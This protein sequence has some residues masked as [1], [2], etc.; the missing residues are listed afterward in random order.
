MG[1]NIKFALSYP[2][3]AVPGQPFKIFII[4]TNSGDAVGSFMVSMESYI[5][6]NQAFTAQ[7]PSQHG[8]PVYANVPADNQPYIF[9]LKE[10]SSAW[11]ADPIM[12]DSWNAV[13]QSAFVDGN[14]FL[15]VFDGPNGT[16]AKQPIQAQ[17][18]AIP[19]LAPTV[20][21]PANHPGEIYLKPYFKTQ[22]AN[23]SAGAT[24]HVTAG[25][26]TIYYATP[27][28]ILYMDAQMRNFGRDYNCFT[29]I[30]SPFHGVLT[31]SI[32]N[33]PAVE[34]VFATKD[35]NV[36]VQYGAILPASFTG[37]YMDMIFRSGHYADGSCSTVTGQSNFQC[38]DEETHFA[39]YN[40]GFF[41]QNKQVLP[42]VGR[43][44]DDVAISFEVDNVGTSSGKMFIK[45]YDADNNL[46]SNSTTSQ[47]TVNVGATASPVIRFKYPYQ[48]DYVGRWEIVNVDTSEIDAMG[49]YAGKLGTSILQVSAPQSDKLVLAFGETARITAQVTNVGE[50]Q[51][52][53]NA[54]LMDANNIVWASFPSTQIMPSNQLG[55]PKTV[56][57]D[58]VMPSMENINLHI[59]IFDETQGTDI[60][61]SNILIQGP[62]P[63]APVF[64]IRTDPTIPAKMLAGE[65]TNFI[66]KIENT[67]GA[68]TIRVEVQDEDNNHA[69]MVSQQGPLLDTSQTW[70]ANLVFTMPNRDVHIKIVT[71]DSYGNIHDTRPLQGSYEI[72]LDISQPPLPK[73][74]YVPLL[75]GGVAGLGLL[76]YLATKKRRG[77]K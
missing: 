27:G 73:T 75:I 46:I 17:I 11:E 6:N 23:I 56:D 54:K 52:R 12:P 24:I 43:Y 49:T 57:F 58:F 74:N 14:F 64:R 61:S 45:V 26:K 30:E 68:D 13:P 35:T 44:L 70:D 47:F 55:A 76:A 36:N 71:I 40:A 19:V 15:D 66:F 32:R 18:A 7:A 53:F 5:Y 39:I 28:D 62:S 22:S 1:A 10:Q 42:V 60:Q 77:K 59:H 69:M 65:Q 51:T 3:E 20:T 50:L 67:G 21:L 37:K 38:P 9:E 4:A 72:L 29:K 63:P 41:Q 33:G 2:A 31:D 25:G 34:L 8:G 48:S 16:G